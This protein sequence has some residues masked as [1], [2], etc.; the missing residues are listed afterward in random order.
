MSS[1]RYYDRDIGLACRLGDDGLQLPTEDELL[2]L[3]QGHLCNDVGPEPVSALL[4]FAR[5]KPGMA[6]LGT[7]EVAFD[8]GMLRVISWKK[9]MGDKA[10]NAAASY[11]VN[12]HMRKAAEPLQAFAFLPE[13]SG[14]L[15]SFPVDRVLRG[16]ARALDLRRVGRAL[17]NSGI[18]SGRVFRRRSSSIELLRYKP[19]RRAVLCLHAK[20]KV[21][22][23]SGA[24]EAG[25]RRLGVR[26]LD[27]GEARRV[28]A[29]REKC[30]APTL[31]KL[32]Y[33]EPEVGLLFE[34][35][36]EG[37]PVG[38]VEFADAEASAEVLSQ[39]HQNIGQAP[40]RS[41]SRDGAYQLLS[42]V[43][44]LMEKANA[45]STAEP[46]TGI[47]WIHGD[48]HPDQFIKAPGALRLVDA[49]AL[50]V[51]APEEDLASWVADHLCHEAGVEYRDA[52]G[53]LIEGYCSQSKGI[54]HAYLRSLVREELVQ[55]AAA[56]LRRLEQSA[57]ERAGDLLNL[58][59]ALDGPSSSA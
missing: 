11:R 58:A 39:L 6:V 18:W 27:P 10:P 42:R 34:E 54:D 8:D 51:G 17:D 46:A 44:A 38:P 29:A 43:P 56:A 31:P 36:I 40:P 45:I 35:W 32:L 20:L 55:R 14:L 23:D 47:C 50:R 26:V 52:V 49:D 41:Y 30:V 5:W 16:A 2:G 3:V 7:W 57:E 22:T 25:S 13:Q 21:R 12:D 9:Y 33:A 4:T 59:R 1:L 28:I 24:D 37:T 48:F 15:S 53:P 19:E